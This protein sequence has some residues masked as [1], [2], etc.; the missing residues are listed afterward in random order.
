MGR[1]LVAGVFQPA[2][3]SSHYTYVL[4]SGIITWHATTALDVRGAIS[5]TIGRPSYDSYAARSSI[6]FANASDQGNPNATSIIVNL[7]N[8]DLKPRKSTNYDVSADYVLSSRYGGIISLAGFYKN[9]QNEIFSSASAGYIYQGVMYVNALVT[10]PTNS[11]G[12]NIKGVEFNAVVNSLEFIHPLLTGFGVSGNAAL[13]DGHLKVPL[14]ADGTRTLNNLVSQPD[15]TANASIFFSQDGLE[16]RTAFNHQGRALRSIVN[17]LPYQDLYF[18]ARNQLD[19]SA[20]YTL[21]DGVAFFAQASNIT[22]TRLTSLTGP[23]INLLKDSY[24][25]PTTIFAGVRFTPHLH[26]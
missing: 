10:R 12:S 17:N 23:N 16:I 14:S 3:T 19:V 13:L 24:S 5:Q 22:H 4:P 8:P 21:R 15:N 26:R 20:T 6:T 1:L 9:I 25:V 18:A 2:P 11:S 7:G